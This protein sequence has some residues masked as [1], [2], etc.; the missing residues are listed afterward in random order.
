VIKPTELPKLNGSSSVGTI[1]AGRHV[2]IASVAQVER[3]DGTMAEIKGQFDARITVAGNTSEYEHPVDSAIEGTDLK[4]RAG[5][6]A[7]TAI[8]LERIERLEVSQYD[9]LKTMLLWT[10]IGL[11]FVVLVGGAVALSQQH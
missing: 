3:P 1:S 6:R 8:P 7:L 2:V 5:N 10:G 4:V 9:G 11:G